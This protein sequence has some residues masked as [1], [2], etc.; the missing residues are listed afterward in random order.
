MSTRPPDVY[1]TK[2]PARVEVNN[3]KPQ[4]YSKLQ[5]RVNNCHVMLYH[6]HG[7]TTKT[8]KMKPEG[9]TSFY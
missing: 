8:D 3:V 4:R 7:A 6:T 2:I 5:V 9:N 1:Y